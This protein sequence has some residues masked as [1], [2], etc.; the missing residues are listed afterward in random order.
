MNALLGGYLEPQVAC[1]S[2]WHRGKGE[3]HIEN[4]YP[5]QAKHGL[6]P[7]SCH[8]VLEEVRVCAFH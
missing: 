8:A 1:S 5:T 3:R 6:T 4:R 7:I 2:A